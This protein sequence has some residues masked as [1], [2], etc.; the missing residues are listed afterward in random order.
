M[1]SKL[2]RQ[3]DFHSFDTRNRFNFVLARPNSAAY[4]KS[5]YYEGRKLWNALPE[6]IRTIK[7]VGVFRLRL[8]E[9]YLTS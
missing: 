1:L 5:P 2:K 7:S 6:A 4:Q 3:A 8:R 9:M